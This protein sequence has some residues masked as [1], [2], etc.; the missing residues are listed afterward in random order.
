MPLSSWEREKRALSTDY[1]GDD[2]DNN[3]NNGYG[4]DSEYFSSDPV[5]NEKL[6]KATSG[7]RGTIKRMVGKLP[8]D[9][10]KKLVA[11]FMIDCERRE[12]IGS[13]SKGLYIT[14]LNYL[15]RHHGYKKSLMAMTEDDIPSFLDSFE[16][17]PGKIPFSKLRMKNPEHY[18]PYGWITYRD[19]IASAIKK[20][21]KYAHF[22][23]L[24]FKNR[25]HK[26]SAEQEAQIPQLRKLTFLGKTSSMPRSPIKSKDKWDDEDLVTA[27]KYIDGNPRLALYIIMG[28]EMDARPSEILQVRLSDIDNGAIDVYS[29]G[30][31]YAYV[32]VGRY[33]K[34]KT[35][36]KVVMVHSLKYYHEWRRQHPRAKNDPNAFVF[37]STEYSTYPKAEFQRQKE[38]TPSISVR[39][40]SLE[41]KKLQ[42][43]YL[44]AI[45]ADP[46]LPDEERAK[47]KK[48]LSRRFNP[49]IFRHSGAQRLA[50]AGVSEQSLRTYHG[51]KRK[52]NE[53]IG[54]YIDE[55]GD[56][57]CNE[58]LRVFYKIDVTTNANKQMQQAQLEQ[59]LRG[60]PCLYCNT[61]NL[62]H[63]QTCVKCNKLI[64]TGKI[65]A[66]IEG[67]ERR[68]SELDEMKRNQL[69]LEESVLSLSKLIRQN[70]RGVR[71]D[72]EAE[73]ARDIA[74]E[75]MERTEEEQWMREPEEKHKND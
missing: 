64:D 25:R 26:L 18:N 31:E 7:L 59:E 1:A 21:Y 29:D 49:Y 71:G 58:V 42:R 13:D 51:W 11:D 39:S 50:N 43:Q 19:Q 15:C 17:I 41:L 73:Y 63:A 55:D 36:R 52:S 22:R 53:T 30:T 24:I 14:A 61:W 10:D 57:A 68:K 6:R 8:T 4:D 9:M 37:I 60:R 16:P 65:K 72:E 70:L 33:G 2:D 32:Q 69:K 62:P 35:P 46:N 20:F 27:L 48:L 34:R 23:D 44:P 75:M 47:I 3:N 56:A 45:L 67:D 40:L 38:E 28:M 54:V 66:L 5:I 74:G 12:T